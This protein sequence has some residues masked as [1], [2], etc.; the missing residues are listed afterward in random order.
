MKNKLIW[1]LASIAL[2]GVAACQQKAAEPAAVASPFL[3]TASI[4]DLMLSEVDPA[5]D[6]LWESV[7]IVI[8]D[9]GTDKHQPHTDEEWAEARHRAI[10]LIEATNLLSMPG[11]RVAE[12]GQK[13]QDEGQ[14]GI[15]TSADMQKLI[16]ADHQSFVLLAHGL[17][18]AGMLALKAIDAKD[19]NA[20]L[21]SGGVIDAACEACHLKYWYPNQGVP[22]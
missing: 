21:E 22:Q 2:L 19:A 11:R 9:K 6:Y 13:L 1:C 14:P 3:L 16:D 5:A 7:S 15:L 8:S 20:L 18:D 12:E 17:H 10:T 4:H